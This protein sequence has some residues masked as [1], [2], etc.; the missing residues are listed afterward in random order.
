MPT[1]CLAA[2]QVL[3]V[4][5]DRTGFV[6]IKSRRHRQRRSHHVKVGRVLSQVPRGAEPS[7]K[8]HVFLQESPYFSARWKPEVCCRVMLSHKQGT[9]WYAQ[10]HLFSS[11]LQCACVEICRC[12]CNLGSLHLHSVYQQ[13]GICLNHQPCCLGQHL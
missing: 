3:E 5:V 2:Q 7:T 8:V 11:Y 13:Q 10:Y 1:W 6:T 4:Q 12:F 9:F